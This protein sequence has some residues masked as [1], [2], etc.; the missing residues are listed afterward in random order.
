MTRAIYLVALGS[1]WVKLSVIDGYA[2]GWEVFSQY[3]T[4]QYW[5]DS[6]GL[7]KEPLV[8][9]VYTENWYIPTMRN[10]FLCCWYDESFGC[11]LEEIGILESEL[12]K[13]SRRFLI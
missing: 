8:I 6:Y 2:K 7:E 4:Q 3:P 10:T 13:S 9:D 5:L 12:E 11:A 1:A